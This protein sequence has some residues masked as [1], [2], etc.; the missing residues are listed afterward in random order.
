[1]THITQNSIYLASEIWK[2]Q[3][4]LH[5]IQLIKGFKNITREHPNFFY[6]IWFWFCWIFQWE[7]NWIFN[8]SHTVDLN[9]MK[10]PQCMGTHVHRG[11]SNGAKCPIRGIMVW[12][13][14]M[15][16]KTNKSNVYFCR[17]LGNIYNFLSFINIQQLSSDCWCMC[18]AS[19]MKPNYSH[20]SSD[21]C[22]PSI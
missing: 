13:I 11:L 6:K 10:P 4:H 2:S 16:N 18:L 14:P 12:V 19:M 17:F 22:S 7:N 5:N 21:I 3:I 20:C 1:M 15:W 9:I 8:K